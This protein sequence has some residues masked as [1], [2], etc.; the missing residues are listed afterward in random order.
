MKIVASVAFAALALAAPQARATNISYT[1]VAAHTEITGLFNSSLLSLLTA[2][3][4]ASSATD[5]VVK[6]TGY[7]FSGPTLLLGSQSGQT[8]ELFVDKS[9]S[10]SS[11]TYSLEGEAL[12]TQKKVFGQAVTV[13]TTGWDYPL[14]SVITTALT[15][16]TSTA[17]N[18]PTFTISAP[19]TGGGNVQAPGPIAGAGLPALILI[20]GLVGF[21]R[22]RA[23]AV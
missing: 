9:T 19:G 1:D 23:A 15:G 7:T 10:G 12:Q 22:R 17:N 14:A 21:V 2:G 11:V 6:L 20:G 5:A 8:A 18:T 4:S 13:T 3:I 16:Q